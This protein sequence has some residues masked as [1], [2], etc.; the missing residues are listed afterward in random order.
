MKSNRKLWLGDMP[1]GCCSRHVGGERNMALAPCI[2]IV[3]IVV[4]RAFLQSHCCWCFTVVAEVM[5]IIRVAIV[6]VI[7]VVVTIFAR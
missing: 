5:V 4:S 7:V 6:I 3:I 2:V 1:R